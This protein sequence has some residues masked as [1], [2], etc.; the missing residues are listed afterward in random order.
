MISRIFS[1]CRLSI[2]V[3]LALICAML[4]PTLA[5]PQTPSQRKKQPPASKT[6]KADNSS[7]TDKSEQKDSSEKKDETTDSTAT[8]SDAITENRPN[9]TLDITK[10]RLVL[11]GIA[12][13]AKSL[14]LN[15]RPFALADVADAYCRI[16]RA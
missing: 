15:T 9:S 3:S 8:N 12:E 13:D 16:D 7:K 4:L 5:R 2:P 6:S 11:D 10:L 14:P 1:P